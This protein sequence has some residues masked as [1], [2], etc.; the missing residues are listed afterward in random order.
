MLF[1]TDMYVCMKTKVCTYTIQERIQTTGNAKEEC[2][3]QGGG[4]PILQQQAEDFGIFTL[5]TRKLI[6]EDLSL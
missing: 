5:S 1:M 6:K 2:C 3:S 4:V